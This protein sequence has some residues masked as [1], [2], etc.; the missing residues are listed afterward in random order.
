MVVHKPTS[1]DLHPKLFSALSTAV[2]AASGAWIRGDWCLPV[3]RRGSP[4]MSLGALLALWPFTVLLGTTCERLTTVSAC[5]CANGEHETLASSDGLKLEAGVL[6][7]TSTI[8]PSRPAGT[9]RQP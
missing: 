6:R 4:S 3:T 2:A 7:E 5:F 9:Q 8:L 1:Y